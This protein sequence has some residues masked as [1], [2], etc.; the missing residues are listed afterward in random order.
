VRSGATGSL[1]QRMWTAICCTGTDAPSCARRRLI[2]DEVQCGVKLSSPDP[3]PAL[4]RRLEG[5]DERGPPI[6]PL[7]IIFSASPETHTVKRLDTRGHL[8]DHERLLA[9]GAANV[10]AVFHV[11]TGLS[12]IAAKAVSFMSINVSSLQERPSRQSCDHERMLFDGDAEVAFGF[13]VETGG[14]RAATKRCPSASGRCGRW[15]FREKSS[16]LGA[17]PCPRRGHCERRER[18]PAC[19]WQ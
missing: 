9:D 3:F 2:L 5:T 7:G 14:S 13:H 16:R 8:L 4:R 1:V 6:G 12:G 18:P 11:E 17:P 19:Q 15:H 10:A